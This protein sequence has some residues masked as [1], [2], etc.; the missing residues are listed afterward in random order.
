MWVEIISSGGSK[1]DGVDEKGTASKGYLTSH[2]ILKR[3]Q[4]LTDT[5][6]DYFREVGDLDGIVRKTHGT[7]LRLSAFD[8]RRVP[9]MDSLE[10]Q[11]S[12]RFGVTSENWGIK[13]I[14]SLKTTGSPTSSCP[15]GEFI[16]DRMDGTIIRFEEYT[17]GDKQKYRTI[18][19]DG[20]EMTN[21][22]AGFTLD[23]TYYPLT[24]WMG[25]SRQ[26]YKDDLMAGVRIY[27]RGKI[28]AQT[29]IFNMKAGFTGEY[30]IRS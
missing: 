27:C 3:D 22:A 4:I 12:Q 19:P 30:D 11:L 24:G 8:H 17:E 7:T 23:G 10:R 29:H 28:A 16:V 18:G 13:L 14:D 6:A 5:D 21:V 15:V 9:A 26:P 20:N 1:I 2:L 25:Y